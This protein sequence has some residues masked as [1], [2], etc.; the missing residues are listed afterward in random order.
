MK[1]IPPAPDGRIPT[2]MTIRNWMERF[3]WR[4]RADAL[5]AE[6]SIRLDREAIENRISI[7]RQ[8]AETGETLMNK[9]VNYILTEDNPFKDNPSAAVRAIVAGSEMQ[10][11]YAAQADKLAAI[12]Q[13]SDK[14]IESEIMRLLGKPNNDEDMVDAELE[15][16]NDPESDDNS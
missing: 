6:V 4:Q 15:E 14:Q 11:K 7:L 12:A 10:F 13:M 3:G 8:L 5:D 1:F 16:V 2:F 9:G